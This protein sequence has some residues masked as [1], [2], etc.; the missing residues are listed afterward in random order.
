MTALRSCVCQMQATRSVEFSRR[1]VGFSNPMMGSDGEKVEEVDTS[2]GSPRGGAF[3]E[4]CPVQHIAKERS[5]VLA[6]DSV[7]WE[8]AQAKRV[9]RTQ[10]FTKR[11]GNACRI[12]V[13][14][15]CDTH[16]AVESRHI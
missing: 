11:T 13:R 10:R 2:S 5:R 9:T 4:F 1:T 6:V 16:V 3:G 12:L 14:L 7:K 15:R 8:N